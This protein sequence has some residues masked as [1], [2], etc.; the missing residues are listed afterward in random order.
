MTILN[1]TFSGNQAASGG[2]I[3]FS[4]PRV[5]GE[6]FLTHVTLADDTAASEGGGLYLTGSAKATLNAVLIADNSVPVSPDCGRSP[7]TLIVAKYSLIETGTACTT[8]VGSIG[9]IGGDPGLGP[10]QDHGGTSA[11]HLPGAPG[12]ALDAQN[13][14]PLPTSEDQRGVVRPQ[15]SGCDIGR[16]N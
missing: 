4:N 9:N 5:A 7:A 1:S 12:L 6:S 3:S 16:W 8:G 15:G 13:R 11:T 10:L 2:G 14:G